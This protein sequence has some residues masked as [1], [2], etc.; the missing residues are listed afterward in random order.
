M[1]I[2][3]VLSE[4][5]V[6]GYTLN[7]TEADFKKRLAAMSDSRIRKAV[8]QID[9]YPFPVILLQEHSKR[10]GP[11]DARRGARIIAV[12]LS[13]EKAERRRLLAKIRSG[14]KSMSDYNVSQSG[15]GHLSKKTLDD[16]HKKARRAVLEIQECA[17]HL[18]KVNER[19]IKY[20]RMLKEI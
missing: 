12:Q 7:R 18:E 14:S 8:E 6:H 19:V 20:E 5:T 11:T 4:I 16:I 2:G 10:F 13:K 3:K 17:I 15:I 1:R 9:I